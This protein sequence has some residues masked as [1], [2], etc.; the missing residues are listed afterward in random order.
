MGIAL[1]DSRLLVSKFLKVTREETLAAC[2]NNIRK[3]EKK[4]SRHTTIDFGWQN[5]TKETKRFSTVSISNGG[6][7]RRKKFAK[8]TQLKEVEESITK[9]FFPSGKSLTKGRLSM[10][11]SSFV[12]ND[13]QV[14]CDLNQTIGAY[15]EKNSLKTCKFFLRTRPWTPGLATGLASDSDSTSD[16]EVERTTFRR[17]TQNRDYQEPTSLPGASSSHPE[18]LENKVIINL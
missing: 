18:K 12:S 9:T 5:W 13:K 6:G 1:G 15:I 11:L 17:P 7:L 10:M 2:V 14:I 3:K 16:F 4:E 8:D